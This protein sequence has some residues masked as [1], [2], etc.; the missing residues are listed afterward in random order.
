MRILLVEDDND[1]ASF[2]AR[3]LS[4][5]NHE[6]RIARDGRDALFMAGDEQFDA[7]VL[8]RRLPLLDGMT[9]LKRLRSDH[10]DLPVVMLT[11][12][13]DLSDRVEGLDAGADD[14]LVKPVDTI[15]LVARLNAIARRPPAIVEQ[16]ILATRTIKVN[17]LQQKVERAGRRITLTPIEY[18]LLVELL[19]HCDRVVTRQM[20]L[21]SVWGYDFEPKTNIVVSQ[22]ARVRANLNCDDLPDVIR[23]VHG[24]GYTIASD[25]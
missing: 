16:G 5:Y 20:L 18:K 13:G 10:F 17:L 1:S 23:T 22:I 2:L 9:V 19:R 4:K 6:V 14:Y 11:A 21:K 12:L 25:V 7:V 24:S 8:D 3:E 15:E